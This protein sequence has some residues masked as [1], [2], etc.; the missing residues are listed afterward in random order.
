MWVAS[1]SMAEKTRKCVLS[2][3]TQ[4]YALHLSYNQVSPAVSSFCG[5]LIFPLSIFKDIALVGMSQLVG[6]SSCKPK[7]WE[8][9]SW[10]EHIPSLRVQS[11]V[12]T[13]AKNKLSMFHSHINVSFSLPTPNFL[14]V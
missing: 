14:S 5:I 2:F 4:K 10:S 1:K 12:G 8:F 3:S 11:P 13:H 9:N 7:G 6:V